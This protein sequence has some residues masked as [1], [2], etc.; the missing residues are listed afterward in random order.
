MNEQWTFEAK[1]SMIVICKNDLERLKTNLFFEYVFPNQSIMY[2]EIRQI[3]KFSKIFKVLYKKNS[4]SQCIIIVDIVIRRLT[5]IQE[6]QIRWFRIIFRK[7]YLVNRDQ[8]NFEHAEIEM[9]VY[10]KQSGPNNSD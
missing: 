8:L 3:F 9:F 2:Y 5:H 7:Y 6:L 4:K 10:T 1:S